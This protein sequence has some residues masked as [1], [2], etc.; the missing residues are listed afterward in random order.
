MLT[1]NDSAMACGLEQSD[2][3]RVLIQ[4]REAFINP[5]SNTPPIGSVAY[6]ELQ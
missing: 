6:K 1:N 3:T 5:L 2:I 4:T